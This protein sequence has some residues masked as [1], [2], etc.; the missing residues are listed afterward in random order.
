MV[1]LPFPKGDRRIQVWLHFFALSLALK[2]RLDATRK[3]PIKRTVNNYT[4][5]VGVFPYQKGGQNVSTRNLSLNDSKV[6]CTLQFCALIDGQVRSF[7]FWDKN[8]LHIWN[9]FLNSLPVVCLKEIPFRYYF[10]VKLSLP[11]ILHLWNI[12]SLA[13]VSLL[14]VNF[15]DPQI[16]HSQNLT[17]LMSLL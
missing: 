7:N 16:I 11:G 6:H 8:D 2:Q 5:H 3:W 12:F 10:K 4:S 14:H 17:N 9:M 15:E 13:T 1:T